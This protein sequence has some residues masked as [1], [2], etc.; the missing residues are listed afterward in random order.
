[1][2]AEAPAETASRARAETSQSGR[3]GLRSVATAVRAPVDPPPGKGE[4]RQQ[5]MLHSVTLTVSDTRCSVT[6]EVRAGGEQS[7]AVAE[8][9]CAGS[10]IERLVAEATVR[11]AGGLDP[12]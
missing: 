11:A 12:D 7:V 3:G 10:G 9:A 2:S 4:V 6:V 1:M 8:G 5:M